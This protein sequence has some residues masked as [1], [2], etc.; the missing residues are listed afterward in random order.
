[1]RSSQPRQ[2]WR[3]SGRRS[4]FFHFRFTS[5]RHGPPPRIASSRSPC[6][7]RSASAS[8]APSAAPVAAAGA[9][10]AA[11]R[12]GRGR[13]SRPPPEDRQQPLALPPALGAPGGGYGVGGQAGGQA[14]G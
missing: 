5:F 13:P 14:G 12:G 1:M 8:A 4:N 7:R 2:I 6:H 9:G 3:G 11:G 10:G